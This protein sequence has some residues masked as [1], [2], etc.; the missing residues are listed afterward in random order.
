VR[1]LLHGLQHPPCIIIFP[2]HNVYGHLKVAH[3]QGLHSDW[4]VTWRG[5]T[6]RKGGELAGG[7]G[8]APWHAVHP[9]LLPDERRA[10]E[11]V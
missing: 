3:S 10:A 11:Y 8:A 4:K 1:Q 5:V 6:E 2:Y 9:M 7:A